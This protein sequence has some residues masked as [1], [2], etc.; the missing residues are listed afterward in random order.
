[1][2]VYG[3]TPKEPLK[4]WQRIVIMFG[5]LE[6]IVF[7]ILL[8]VLF[9]GCASNKP[10]L[11]PTVMTKAHY[12]A[13][14]PAATGSVEGA[15]RYDW[16]FTLPT[17]PCMITMW[18]AQWREIL[19]WHHDPVSMSPNVAFTEMPNAVFVKVIPDTILP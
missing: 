2:S 17:F 9:C 4:L 1:M 3:P 19:T 15:V 16:S 6:F 7:V 14:E 11:P 12:T 5:I 8:I 18:D 10:P 13:V